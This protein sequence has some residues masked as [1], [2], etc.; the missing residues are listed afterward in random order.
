MLKFRP[1]ND[2][3]SFLDPLLGAKGCDAE[4]TQLGAIDLGT[5]VRLS[6]ATTC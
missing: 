2:L 3:I 4:V 5:E 1:L 6:L